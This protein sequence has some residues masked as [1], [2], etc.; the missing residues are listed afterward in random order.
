MNTHKP[1]LF[2]SLCL[3]APSV[4]ASSVKVGF[5]GAVSVVDTSDGVDLSLRFAPGQSIT[6]TFTFEDTT[7]TTGFDN[8]GVFTGAVTGLDIDIAGYTIGWAPGTNRLETNNDNLNGPFQGDHIRMFNLG[9]TGAGVNGAALTNVTL[10]LSDAQNTVFPDDATTQSLTPTYDFTQF[11]TGALFLQFIDP[12]GIPRLGSLEATLGNFA[13]VSEPLK[14]TAVLEQSDLF[15]NEYDAGDNSDGTFSASSQIAYGTDDLPLFNA[16]FSTDKTVTLRVE[17]PAGHRFIIDAP[18]TF[19]DERSLDLNV[20]TVADTP[21]DTGPMTDLVF[22]DLTGSAP[23]LT[24]E[25]QD[26][27]DGNGDFAI[28]IVGSFDGPSS[29]TALEATFQVPDDFDVVQIDNAD[30]FA[31]LI[32]QIRENSS[33]APLEDPELWL[34]IEPIPEPSSLALLGLG[35]LLVYRPRRNTKSVTHS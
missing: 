23:N 26:Q 35:G 29:F 19:S 21:F 22:E 24:G 8:Q 18:D 6:G 9:F 31:Q 16:D 14:Y 28:R 2:A 27:D 3:L 33:G 4:M 32:G 10:G 17:A 30:V 7:P 34:R 20:G 13:V 12:S 25:F 15:L 11:E 5:T 1:I